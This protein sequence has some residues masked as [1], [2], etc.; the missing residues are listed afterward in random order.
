MH[1]LAGMDSPSAAGSAAQTRAA[2]G[3]RTLGRL[4]HLAE[5][6]NLPSILEHGLLSTA[7]LL[8]L[9]GIAEPRRTAI[10]RTHRPDAMRLSASVMIRDQRPMPPAALGR[11][12]AGGLEPADWYG[13]LNG[14]V[15]LWPDLDRMSRQLGACGDRAQVVLT[16]DGAAV[17][18][19]F[20][21]QAFVSP[22]NSGNARRKPAV[23]GRETLLAW[24]TWQAQGWP[25]GLRSRPPAEVLI[26]ERIPARAPYLLSIQSAEQVLRD[27]GQETPS[28]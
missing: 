14:F 12:L 10:L 7:G 22:I 26:G 13:L 2:P 28:C 17:L 25:S 24:R 16:F 8:D 1:S 5:A 18:D 6:D 27:A 9:A 20:A 15:F 3:R 4:Y 23:R 21:D 11:A 19:R